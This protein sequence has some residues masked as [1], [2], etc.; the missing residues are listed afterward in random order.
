MKI[1][2][3]MKLKEEVDYESLCRK[4]ENQIDHLTTEIERQQKQRENDKFKLERQL[5]E[6]KESIYNTEKDLIKR[7]EVLYLYC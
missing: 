6:C 7:S 1:V 3:T 2:N 4:L 5:V